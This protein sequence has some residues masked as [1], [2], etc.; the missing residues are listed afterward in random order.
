MKN[1][2]QTE[3]DRRNE[4]EMENGEVIRQRCVWSPNNSRGDPPTPSPQP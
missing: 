3:G 4:S 1:V 2:F